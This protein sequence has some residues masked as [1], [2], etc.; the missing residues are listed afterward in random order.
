MKKLLLV[1]LFLFGVYT[2]SAQTCIWNTQYLKSL[3]FDKRFINLRKKVIVKANSYMELSPVD[4]TQ[5]ILTFEPNSHYFLSIPGYWWWDEE[6]GKYVN[7]DG[8][9]NPNVKNP[10]KAKMGDLTRRLTHYSVAY[11]ITRDKQYYDAYTRQIKVWFI[12]E[13]S[14][15]Y[16]NFEYSQLV[17][18]YNDN[19]GRP[20]GIIDSYQLNNILDS[21][22]LITSITPFD[23]QLDQKFK[24]WFSELEVWLTTSKNGIKNAKA[25]ANCS[26]MQDLIMA[27]I[28]LLLGNNKRFCEMSDTF[29]D[30]R[31]GRQIKNDGTQPTELKR[32]KAFSYSVY[33]LIHIVDFCLLMES[34]RKH[35]Y[36]E[37]KQTIDKAFQY[38]LNY[39]GN[40]DK[41]PYKQIVP[42][43][44]DEESLKQQ[45]QR[46]Y[47]LKG[48]TGYKG[49][50]KNQMDPYLATLDL[51]L[52]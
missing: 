33:N 5:K 22:R 11:Y 13:S 20:V 24:Q 19:R 12:D 42:F 4:I 18:G 10:D 36:S 1:S 15:M 47:R 25:D 39:I 7:I 52:R 21:Y 35:F 26:V 9:R 31:L 27:N 49:V 30:V 16:P 14:K 50:K 51:I 38:L 34:Q 44:D 37:N 28:Y 40:E 41:W 23:T 6:K 29:K 46:M 48:F 32:T 3:K 8:V 17:P 45:I 2:L 43:S